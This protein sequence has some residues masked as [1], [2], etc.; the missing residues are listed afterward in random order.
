LSIE[1]ESN[2]RKKILTAIGLT[3]VVFLW[4]CGGGGSATNG[5]TSN[6][7]V[8]NK[9]G[10]PRVDVNSNSLSGIAARGM[11][12]A[13]ASVVAKCASGKE[14]V[15]QTDVNGRFNLELGP[16]N[17]GDF[18]CMLKAS[19]TTPLLTLFSYAE[20]AGVVNINPLTDLTLAKALKSNPASIFERFGSA[21]TSIDTLALRDA[22][23]FAESALIS[24]SG[25]NPSYSPRPSPF[26]SEFKIGDGRDVAFDALFATLNAANL[27]YQGLLVE[28]V[29]EASKRE[30]FAE[31]LWSQIV[32]KRINPVIT[33]FSCKPA[34]DTDSYIQCTIIGRNLTYPSSSQGILSK[35][36]VSIFD[37]ETAIRNSPTDVAKPPVC[38]VNFYTLG[39]SKFRSTDSKDPLGP[40]PQ[41]FFA[42]EIVFDCYAGIIPYAP[43]LTAEVTRQDGLQKE[44]Y[45]PYKSAFVS[46]ISDPPFVSL[47]EISCRLGE[48]IKTVVSNPILGLIEYTEQEPELRF[49][50]RLVVGFQQ[51]FN[52]VVSKVQ[53]SQQRL[54]NILQD[55]DGESLAGANPDYLRYE[56][57]RCSPSC[58]ASNQR[59]SGVFDQG[60]LSKGFAGF[61]NRNVVNSTGNTVWLYP[62][63][64]WSSN[65]KFVSAEKSVICPAR[66]S[67]QRYLR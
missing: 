42:E 57:P 35:L 20:E 27:S 30:S 66:V 19:S 21:T 46:I 67:S 22:A 28:V 52:V 16:S 2:M 60:E 31:T 61:L 49:D 36:G 23:D 56:L 53:L 59:I 47:R 48:P 15:G 9:P 25:F 33:D 18:P 44:T 58:V 29:R 12:L 6:Q 64:N 8:S 54:G 51:Y 62:T 24:I 37:D 45:Q 14:I 50:G 26:T 32:E 1:E 7:T 34:R 55:V 65:S 39:A 38:Q 10:T 4:S 40:D 63:I 5:S 17:F 43:Y 11:P 41:G 3:S 13:N